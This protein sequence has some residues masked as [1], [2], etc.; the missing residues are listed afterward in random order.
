MILGLYKI[1]DL[2]LRSHVAHTA[3]VGFFSSPLHRLTASPAAGHF[4][5]GCWWKRPPAA[6]AGVA[7]GTAV[8]NHQNNNFPSTLPSSPPSLPSS[9][10][11]PRASSRRLSLRFHLPRPGL[12]PATPPLFVPRHSPRTP[13]ILT[14]RLNSLDQLLLSPPQWPFRWTKTGRPTPRE[15][16]RIQNQKAIL[17]DRRPCRRC[18]GSCSP[19]CHLT[20]R[21]HA[22]RIPS[23][24]T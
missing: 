19:V 20:A 24:R 10:T 16:P 15:R 13:P 5:F 23:I 12:G 18:W 14:A 17:R 8:S 2:L 22:R 9:S 6:Q 3:R 1:F 11:S 4:S 7:L 21:Q